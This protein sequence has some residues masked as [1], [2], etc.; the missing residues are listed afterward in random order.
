MK[1]IVENI[2]KWIEN[3]QE[4]VEKI[5]NDN[6]RNWSNQ[7]YRDIIHWYEYAK[8][9]K[10]ILGEEILS[11]DE[12]NNLINIP[13]LGEIYES[14]IKRILSGDFDDDTHWETLDSDLQYYINELFNYVYYTLKW[15]KGKFEENL[16]PFCEISLV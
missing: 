8:N 16:F 14:N 15:D 1:E 11:I 2:G 5:K 13:E 9:N 6:S 7:K 10:Y 3:N 12:L 4:F